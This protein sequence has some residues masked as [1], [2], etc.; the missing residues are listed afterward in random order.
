VGTVTLINT[1][2]ACG[3]AG[4]LRVGTSYNH[5]NCGSPCTQSTGYSYGAAGIQGCQ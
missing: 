2:V 3:T 1:Q 5:G 4:Y